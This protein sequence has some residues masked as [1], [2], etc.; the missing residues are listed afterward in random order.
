M[1]WVRTG[2]WVIGGGLVAYG[3][4]RLIQAQQNPLQSVPAASANSSLSFDAS[5]PATDWLQDLGGAVVGAKTGVVSVT[6]QGAQ[7]IRVAETGNGQPRLTAYP[8]PPGSGKYSIGFGTSGATEGQTITAEQAEQLFQ[9]HL[10]AVEQAINSKV[11]VVLSAA[12]YDALADFVYNV[13]I[14]AFETSTLLQLLNAGNYSGAAAQ[15]DRWKYAGGQV[16]ADL[17]ARRETETQEFEG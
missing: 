13:G 7:A 4:Y 15:F 5:P 17:E 8:D 1:D 11:T 3:V 2:C 14:E 9:Q 12:Q 16:N 10:Q 6:D